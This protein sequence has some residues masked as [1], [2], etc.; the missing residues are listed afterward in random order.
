MLT[1]RLAFYFSQLKQKH[2]FRRVE[3]N[4]ASAGKKCFVKENARNS[5]VRS[6]V[7]QREQN[8]AG[9]QLCLYLSRDEV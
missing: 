9:R 5:R 1:A 8:G 4:M 2:K 6:F 7:S 3:R